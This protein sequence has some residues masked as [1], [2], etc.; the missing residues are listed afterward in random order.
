MTGERAALPKVMIEDLVRNALLEDFGRAGDLTTTATVP[1]G[2]RASAVL[3]ARQP[4]TVAGLDLAA[5]AFELLDPAAEVVV[6]KGDGCRVGAGEEIATI[7]ADARALLS[8]ERVALNFL[9]HLSGIATAAATL[10]DAVAGRCAVT[11]TRKTTP[12]L[13]A[14]EKYAV[15]CGGGMNHR[16]GLDDA[17]LIKDN[18]IALA[19]GVT[20]AVEQVLAQVGHLVA[21][22]VEVDTLDQLR[23]LLEFSDRVDAVL[24][25]NMEPAQ[26]REA[27]ELIDGR[28]T[29]E[30]SGRITV[31]TAPAIAETGVDLI[32]AGWLTHSAAVLDIGLD[33]QV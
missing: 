33:I 28:L 30:A 29:A 25:D 17:V 26:L 7:T 11:C 15:R 6:S 21:I 18:H 14:V 8:G 24:L 23:E 20:A 9:G 5:L 16:T 2:M 13:R 19:G 3:A 10:V 4:G 1:A 22:E 27:V 31:E 12:G 32:S